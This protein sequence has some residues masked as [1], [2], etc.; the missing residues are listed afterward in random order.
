MR[1]LNFR[2]WPA[3]LGKKLRRAYRYS[4]LRKLQLWLKGKTLHWALYLAFSFL[5]TGG[6]LGFHFYLSQFFYVVSIDGREVGLVRDAGEIEQYLVELNLRCSALYDMAVEP[7][8]EIVLLREYRFDGK[9]D[10]EAVKEALRQQITL[11]TEAVML[12]VNQV[13]AVPLRSATEI[14]AVVDLLSSVFTRQD[15]GAKLLEVKLVEEIGGIPCSVS[16]DAVCSPEEAAELLLCAADLGRS[17]LQLASRQG[18][19]LREAAAA[20]PAIHVRTV[21]EVKAVETIPYDKSYVY[22]DKMWY[23]QSHVLI[24]GKA[25]KKEVT[26]HVTRENGK[27]IS[28]KIVGERILE[29]PVTQVIE[30]GTSRAPAIGTGRFLWPVTGGFV[31]SGYRTAQRPDHIGIDIYHPREKKT[32]ILAADSGVVVE[33]G[34]RYRQG[35]YIV[36]YHGGYYTVYAHTSVNYVSAGDKVV[37]GQTIALMGNSGRTFGRTGVHLH[38]EIRRCDGSGVWGSWYKNPPVNPL[39]FFKP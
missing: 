29:E 11:K 39:S 12:T 10:A 24:P 37:R 5:L 2:L 38:F 21:E 31:T 34:Y 25:G 17:R 14:S 20:L 27:E 8:Q 7:E 36:I 30:K 16:P 9:A 15:G 26:Y 18:E 19:L 35:N 4:E 33:A 32:P 28:R 22:N 23:A 13:P 6:L 1:P 3:A